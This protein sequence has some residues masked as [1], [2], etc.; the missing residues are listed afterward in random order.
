MKPDSNSQKKAER[1]KSVQNDKNSSTKYLSQYY[2]LENESLYQKEEI[3]KLKDNYA[4]MRAKLHNQK[5]TRSKLEQKKKSAAVKLKNQENDVALLSKKNQEL[6]N[7]IERYR[8]RKI[9]KATDGIIK[10]LRRIKSKPSIKSDVKKVADESDYIER[11]DKIISESE[12]PVTFQFEPKYLEDIKV[13]IIMDEFS[14]N[15]FKFEFNALVVGPDNWREIFQ[16]ESPDLFLCE[17][18]WHGINPETKPWTRKI[19]HSI[20][21][22]KENRKELLEILEYCKTHHIPSIFWNK[23]DPTNFKFF[24][25]TAVKFD[26]VF[27]S[28]EE[29]INCYKST[30]GHESVHSLMFA[31]QPRLFNPIEEEERTDDVIF[32]GSWYAHFPDRCKEMSTIFNQIIKSGYNLKI[33]DRAFYNEDPRRKFPEEYRDFL[34]PPVSHDKMAKIYK[35]SRYAVNINSVTDSNTMFARRAFE[36]ILCNT[37]VLSNHSKGLERLFKDTIVFMD[38]NKINLEHSKEMRLKNLYNVLNN[39]TYTNR[40][41]QILDTINYP[42]LETDKTVTLYYQTKTPEET[43]NAIKHF[44]TID[45]PYKKAMVLEKNEDETKLVES[46]LNNS[47]IIITPINGPEELSNII[48]NTPY[49]IFSDT[50]LKSDFIKKA[51][52]HYKYIETKYGIVEGTNFRFEKSNTTQN[53]LFNH[54]EFENIIKKQ[55]ENEAEEIPV[56]CIRV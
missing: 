23:E 3:E 56:Y 54:Q 52:L 8:S 38:Q 47:N 29:C 6:K 5:R 14:Y 19:S 24:A 42:Y 25:D 22:N 9:V 26:H 36:L 17:S 27:T 4:Q 41:K 39:H 18:A 21:S 32:A 44:Q 40:F 33:Y 1:E 20:K 13:A 15:S 30:F 55:F 11:S 43:E 7:Q 2:E 12:E 31:A 34:N 53:T 48:N 45:Y 51:V 35:E 46:K 28:A 50:N 49:F 37:L 10:L 16:T